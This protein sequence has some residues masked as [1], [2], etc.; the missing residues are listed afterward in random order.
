MTEKT[1]TFPDVVRIEASGKCNF[2]CIH[3]PTGIAPNKRPVLDNK[4]FESILNQFITNDFIPRVVVLYHGGE[5]L[6]NK[7]L[8]DYI[9][10]LK[11]IGVQKTVITTNASLLK[12]E[13]AEKLILAGLDEIKTSFDGNSPEESMTIR[14]NSQFYRDAENVRT[15]YKVRKNLGKTT[16]KI[17]I[18]N[19]QICSR[20]SLNNLKANNTLTLKNIP[21]YLTSFFKEEKDDIEFKSHPAMIWPGYES[22]GTFEKV[23]FP[24]NKPKYC[25]SLFETISIASNGN[26]LLCCYDLKEELVMGNVFEDSIFSIWNSSQ[27]RTI[28]DNFKKNT[29]TTMC[30]NCNVVSPCYL[31]RAE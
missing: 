8:P 17:I 28:R 14:R 18:S 11:A 29:Y 7:R 19:V 12:E 16:P 3:C 2:R 27:Y 21:E 15:L 25:G 1:D 26:I 4:Q 5:P 31:T 22:D 10:K 24:S 13:L 9:K 20:D 6:L 23:R 30:K